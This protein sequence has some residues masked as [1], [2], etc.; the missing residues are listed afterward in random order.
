MAKSKIS[1]TIKSLITGSISGGIAYYYSQNGHVTFFV[2]L[3]ITILVL[4]H[5]PK[6]IFARF[7]WALFWMIIALNKYFFEFAG[8]LAGVKFKVGANEVDYRVSIMLVIAFIMAMT[9]HFLFN[10]KLKGSIINIDK[11]VSATNSENINTGN[12]NTK[13]GDF[14]IGN[15]Q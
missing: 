5:D 3:F 1:W 4:L 8:N 15:N 11:S 14:R 7:A 2:F 13:G 12:V 6:K 9:F 10:N